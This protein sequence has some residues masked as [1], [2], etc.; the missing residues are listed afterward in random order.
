MKKYIL[1]ES[2]SKYILKEANELKNWTQI[3]DPLILQDNRE[4]DEKYDEYLE[5][6]WGKENAEIVKRDLGKAFA[7]EVTQFGYMEEDN[8]F[9]RFLHTN[10]CERLQWFKDADARYIYL[11][12]AAANGYVRE[13]DMDGKGYF[14]KK[15]IIF[16]REAFSVSEKVFD[17]Y[18]RILDNFKIDGQPFNNKENLFDQIFFDHGKLRTNYMELVDANKQAFGAKAQLKSDNQSLESIF[19]AYLTPSFTKD[20]L[21]HLVL[22]SLS[23]NAYNLGEEKDALLNI[24]SIP[25]ALEKN[26]ADDRQ[27]RRAWNYVQFNNQKLISEFALN[28]YHDK[29][30][31]DT[32]KDEEIRGLVHAFFNKLG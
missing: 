8:P 26:Q 30:K 6:Y 1:C 3:L 7:Q 10:N 22:D 4:F 18:L 19:K 5:E 2:P 20:K 25:Q 28:I 27:W 16:Y 23:L 9:I 21:F 11:H 31:N 13:K 32:S 24:L 17:L 14:G 12:N 29:H 15:H